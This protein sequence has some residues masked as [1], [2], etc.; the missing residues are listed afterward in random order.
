MIAA[1]P[2][3]EPGGLSRRARPDNGLARSLHCGREEGH[4]LHWT[5]SVEG[6]PGDGRQDC[7]TGAPSR[8]TRRWRTGES[9]LRESNVLAQVDYK[10][11]GA[12]PTFGAGL[13]VGIAEAPRTDAG[14]SG[15]LVPRREGRQQQDRD[16]RTLG[17]SG[18]DQRPIRELVGTR[19]RRRPS[20]PRTRATSG[21]RRGSDL[22]LSR[23]RASRARGKNKAAVRV[24]GT[25]AVGAQYFGVP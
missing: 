21:R 23:P 9:K 7:R 12:R 5:S 13:R 16:E 19:P 17:V 14:P 18:R 10:N 25:L 4:P 11:L 8:A 15:T 2:R 6:P 1:A 24:G 3:S 20:E 22:A